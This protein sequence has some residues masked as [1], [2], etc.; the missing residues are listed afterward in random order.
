M[1]GLCRH[2]SPLWNNLSARFYNYSCFPRHVDVVSLLYRRRYTYGPLQEVRAFASSTIS[3]LSRYKVVYGSSRSSRMPFSHLSSCDSLMFGIPTKKSSILLRSLSDFSRLGTNISERD[4]SEPNKIYFD[5]YTS[6]GI[7]VLGMKL[8]RHTSSSSSPSSGGLEEE[9]E[10]Q[11]MVRVVGSFLAFSNS[12]YMWNS[13]QTAS[14][15]TVE[16]LALLFHYQPKVDVL[17]IGF[18]HGSPRLSPQNFESIRQSF[19]Q[20]RGT[21]VEQLDWV[22]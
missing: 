20:K 21:I 9:A 5:G 15:V 8:P 7:D 18:P 19:A 6:S 3:S 10:N 4:T 11:S 22:R 17:L 14:D 1:R 13:V 16:S 2:D 12:L